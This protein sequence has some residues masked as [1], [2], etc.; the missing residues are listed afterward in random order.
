MAVYC[1]GECKRRLRGVSNFSESKSAQNTRARARLG[2][3]TVRVR[4]QHWDADHFAV[5]EEKSLED[6]EASP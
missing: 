3:N 5:T 4:V 2:G 6:L 1:C